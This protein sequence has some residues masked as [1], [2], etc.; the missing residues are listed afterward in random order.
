MPSCAHYCQCAIVVLAYAFSDPLLCRLQLLIT[1]QQQG[2]LAVLSSLAFATEAESQGRDAIT[3]LLYGLILQ[4]KPRQCAH[5][6]LT[7]AA[8]GK[9]IHFL[10]ITLGIFF[11]SLKSIC[12]F[13]FL[14]CLIVLFVLW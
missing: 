14:E 9:S 2:C 3:A 10:L 4:S 6:T 8:E 13:D 11:L 1:A 12:H 5:P 7:P